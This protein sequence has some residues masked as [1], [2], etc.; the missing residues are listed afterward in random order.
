[1]EPKKHSGIGIASFIISLIS[2]G[3]IFLLIIIA[4]V[5]EA[6]SPTGI[7]EES[8]AAVLIGLA[9]F[10]FGGLSLVSLGLG[11]AGLFQQERQKV[12]AILGTVFSSAILLSTTL[13][14]LIGS[15]IE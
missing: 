5:M 7:D 9:L 4:G 3:F 13:L 6:S 10:F 12:F 11:I 15:A 14:I 8:A 2:G 1:M